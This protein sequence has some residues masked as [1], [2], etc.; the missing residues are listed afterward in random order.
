MYELSGAILA[1]VGIA[2]LSLKL[3]SAV[4]VGDLLTLGW[5]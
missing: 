1:I 5:L 3:S 2:I 4:N